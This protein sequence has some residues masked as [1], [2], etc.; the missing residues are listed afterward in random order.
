[1]FNKSLTLNS[2]SLKQRILHLFR[3][4]YIIHFYR[5]HIKSNIISI[6][7]KYTFSRDLLRRYRNYRVTNKSYKALKNRITFK[8]R[9]KKIYH[10]WQEENYVSCIRLTLLLI[11]AWPIRAIQKFINVYLWLKPALI[12]LVSYFR[13]IIRSI[14]KG[15]T[16]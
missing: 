7:Y 12:K 1:M 6:T 4:S 9:L 13:L 11:F 5:V 3:T 15:I 10:S 8:I 14:R 16:K 2:L